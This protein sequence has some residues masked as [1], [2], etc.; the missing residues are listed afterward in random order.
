M[1]ESRAEKL[2]LG[3]CAPY[4]AL[5][6]ARRARRR[7][8]SSRAPSIGPTR[9]PRGSP[10]GTGSGRCDR[11]SDPLVASSSAARQ[12]RAAAAARRLSIGERT[13]LG[14]QP[15]GLNRPSQ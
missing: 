14:L 9:T 3:G 15:P 6:E 5:P 8:S 7:A 13:A 11:R 2:E 12:G 10:P 1:Q 4:T